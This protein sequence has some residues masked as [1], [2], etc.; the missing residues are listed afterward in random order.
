MTSGVDSL[1]WSEVVLAFTR[2][3]GGA[4]T[5]DRGLARTELTRLDSLSDVFAR[6]T[7]TAAA[8]ITTN[9]R[10]SVAAWLE[11][12]LGNR[13][14]ATRLAHQAAM[15]ENDPAETP[16]LP[17][18]ELEGEL[19]MAVGRPAAAQQAF[20]LSLRRM[21]NRA[22][23]LFGA[24]SAAAQSGDKSAASKYYGQYIAQM[25]HGDGTRPELATAKQ[26]V[27]A[28]SARRP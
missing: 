28:T 10:N 14:E 17:A 2:A 4:R 22:R 25:A 23:S 3:L 12:S 8:R 18:A 13:D 19:L 5:G 9:Q 7:D 15:Q 16:L 6:K 26:F 1:G 27:A 20:E 24:A 11:L 21:P